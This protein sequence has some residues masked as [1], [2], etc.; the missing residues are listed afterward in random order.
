M[1]NQKN[2]T[3]KL[4]Y[5]VNK[6]QQKIS[7]GVCVC[8]YVSFLRYC[9]SSDENHKITKMKIDSAEEKNTHKNT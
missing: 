7:I 5:N 9:V 8:V 3:S 6:L 1:R 2:F 4:C